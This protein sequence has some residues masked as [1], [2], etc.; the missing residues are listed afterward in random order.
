M[1]RLEPRW[2]A[3]IIA[4]GEGVSREPWEGEARRSS[5]GRG[6]RLGNDFIPL[7]NSVALPG[8]GFFSALSPGF[9]ANRLHPGLFS[10]HPFGILCG[11]KFSQFL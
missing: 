2:S 10:C 9:S 5:L 8:L 7:E 3:K 11:K 4:Q 6:D 1:F